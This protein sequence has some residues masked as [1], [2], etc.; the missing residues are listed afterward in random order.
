MGWSEPLPPIDSDQCVLL[1]RDVKLQEAR[2]LQP[3]LGTPEHPRRN[4]L[5]HPLPNVHLSDIKG[6]VLLVKDAGPS[7]KTETWPRPGK[8]QLGNSWVWVTVVEHLWWAMLIDHIHIFASTEIKKLVYKWWMWA[9]LSAHHIRSP[10]TRR[11][12]GVASRTDASA[13]SKLNSL[14]YAALG[15][16]VR[17][18][19]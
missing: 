15:Q 16:N 1:H 11:V 9:V 12:A 5:T 6:V 14:F 13:E 10:R 8:S 17:I 2:L 4:V 3:Q 18:Q 7:W 19:E